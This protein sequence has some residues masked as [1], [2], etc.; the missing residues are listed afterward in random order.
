MRV[1]R[2]PGLL[3]DHSW[4]PVMPWYPFEHPHRAYLFEQL[5]SPLPAGFLAVCLLDNANQA[6][7]QRKP[8]R[9]PFDSPEGAAR[10]EQYL[11]DGDEKHFSYAQ[12]A[13]E[14]LPFLAGPWRRELA[15]H[16]LG[17]SQCGSPGDGGARQRAAGRRCQKL[18]ILGGL[19]GFRI[20]HAAARSSTSARSTTK[21]CRG[22]RKSRANAAGSCAERRFRYVI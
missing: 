18:L 12:S 4:Y 22:I 17:T 16:R 6:Q 11:T 5:I 10:L 8:E 20:P 1:A 14:A 13:A 2:T 9:H 19:L 15:V 3:K 21:G 7:L